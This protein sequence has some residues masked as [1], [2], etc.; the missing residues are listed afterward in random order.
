MGSI[1]DLKSDELRPLPARLV[2][3]RAAGCGLRL[4][5]R[6][7]SGEHARLQWMGSGWE[8]RDL[9]SR[10]G[11]FVDGRRLDSGSAVQVVAGNRISFGA[12]E[13]GF[14]VVDDTGPGAVA[15]NGS[16]GV[17]KAADGLLAI[18]DADQPEWT[19]Y[20][21]ARG[22][23]VCEGTDTEPATIADGHQVSA[24]GTMWTVRLPEVLEGTATVDSGARL[25]VLRLRLAVSRDEEHVQLTLIYRGRETQLESRE[26]GY[27][28]LTLARARVADSALPLAEQGWLDRD[29]LQK[30]LALDSNALNVAIFRARRQLSAADVEG[31]AGI[32]EVRRGQRRL[33]IEPGRLDVVRL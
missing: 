17:C 2:V 12:D 26:H 32:V 10:N 33:G 23:W 9:G 27:V 25:E 15:E 31:A 30:M 7:V 22:L 13:G 1:R 5:E 11:T 3:G 6:T 14:V 21:D 16:G 29:R 24:G 18:A 4:D 20:R 8:V 19:V 28:L